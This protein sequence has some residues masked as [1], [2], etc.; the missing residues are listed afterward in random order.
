MPNV[1]CLLFWLKFW[2]EKDAISA[3]SNE[4]FCPTPK[5]Q[6]LIKQWFLPP[7]HLFSTQRSQYQNWKANMY[8]Y[9]IL[10]KIEP[11][12]HVSESSTRILKFYAL[13][14]SEQKIHKTG[15]K[16]WLTAVFSLG[17]SWLGICSNN[18]YIMFNR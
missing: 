18:H 11:G 4:T 14:D 1:S 8:K 7:T 12:L 15:I 3:G 17:S 13:T 9:S 10:K 6:E 2:L 16:N 5:E